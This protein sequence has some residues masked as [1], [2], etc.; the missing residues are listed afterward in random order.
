MTLSICYPSVRRS[1]RVLASV[2]SLLAAD[3][4]VSRRRRRRP[5]VDNDAT[6]DTRRI[7]YRTL[8]GNVAFDFDANVA[9][10]SVYR[11]WIP[12]VVQMISMVNKPNNNRY[13]LCLSL[14]L[15]VV[16][17]RRSEIFSTHYAFTFNV[18]REN[19]PTL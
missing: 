4:D 15:L 19:Y 9:E 11:I 6:P 5:T 14:L 3:V 17:L 12:A 1:R 7:P 2:P 18:S 13:L 16:D 10:R 8:S